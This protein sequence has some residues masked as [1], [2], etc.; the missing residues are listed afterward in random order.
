[1]KQPIEER[2]NYNQRYG[3]QQKRLKQRQDG[4]NLDSPFPK[5]RG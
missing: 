1:M 2:K 4:S 5:S 3:T